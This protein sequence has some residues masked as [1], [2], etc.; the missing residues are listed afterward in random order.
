MNPMVKKDTNVATI[1]K[2]EKNKVTIYSESP[3]LRGQVYA[4][5]AKLR[6]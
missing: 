5:V 6:E 3:I 1:Y 2:V 4:G